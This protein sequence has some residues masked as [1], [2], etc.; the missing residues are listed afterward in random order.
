MNDNKAFV[1]FMA[2]ILGLPL[3]GVVFEK[4]EENAIKI[5]AIKAGLVQKIDINTK[6][7]IWTKP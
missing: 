1:L 6:L 4:H 3:I 2:I 7:P 5:E